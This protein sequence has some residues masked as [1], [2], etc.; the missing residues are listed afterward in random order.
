MRC[1]SLLQFNL[2]CC[3]LSELFMSSPCHRHWSAGKLFICYKLLLHTAR[4]VCSLCHGRVFNLNLKRRSFYYA[5]RPVENNS[6]F[7]ILDL[8]E[9]PVIEFLLLDENSTGFGLTQRNTNR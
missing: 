4:L 6:E 5:L 2:C 1:N 8:R 7:P 9:S 3:F